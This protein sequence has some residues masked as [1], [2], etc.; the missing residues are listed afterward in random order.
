MR[1]LRFLLKGKFA[2]FRRFY[3]NSSS[4]TYPVP[5]PPTLRGLMGAALGLDP[6]IYPD[7]LAEA[8]FSVRPA[9]AWRTLMQTANLLYVTGPGDV[10]GNQGHTQVPTQFLVPPELV[11]QNLA[12]E[13]L[14]LHPEVEKLV[15][16]LLHPVYPLYLGVAYCPAWVEEVRIVEGKVTEGQ[17]GLV[18]GALRAD[19]AQDFRWEEGF[20]I[21][22]DRY[23]LRLNPDRSL[24]KA[25]DLL[26]EAE[27]RP[28]QVNY[29]GAVFREQSGKSYALL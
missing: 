8:R 11:G 25:A 14:V 27:G 16:A 19:E 21:L 18:W 15:R 4:L 17:N 1:A 26:I 5:P 13:V 23:P 7:Y 28:L 9:G 12:F 2:H 6:E 3:T 10:T 22:R 20:R 29:T 24:N